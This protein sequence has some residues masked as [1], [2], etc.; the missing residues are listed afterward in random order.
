MSNHV[1]PDRLLINLLEDAL[2]QKKLNLA[3]I[4][5]ILDNL[6]MASSESLI[7]SAMTSMLKLT[8]DIY[9]FNRGLFSR[10]QQSGSCGDN[11]NRLREFVTFL[12][13]QA[14]N[15]RSPTEMR[16]NCLPNSLR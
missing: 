5:I 16:D 10:A 13:E 12:M 14:S 4:L 9:Q 3:Y 11:L 6:S 8:D 1:D 2:S 7:S 15:S